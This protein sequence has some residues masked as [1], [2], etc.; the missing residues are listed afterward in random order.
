MKADKENLF[1]LAFVTVWSIFVMGYLN[2]ITI[3]SLEIGV[4]VTPQTGNVLWMGFN[5][6]F[7][8]WIAF[9]N[10]LGLFFGFVIGN[11]IP[12][13]TFNLFSNPKLQFFYAWSTFAIPVILYPFVFQYNVAPFVSLLILGIASGSSLGFFR[14][15]YSLDQINSAMATG[16]VRFIGVHFAQGFIK[17]N[18]KDIPLFYIFVLCIVAFV[19]GAFLYGMAFRFDAPGAT[20]EQFMEYSRFINYIDYYQMMGNDMQ[21]AGLNFGSFYGGLNF[22]SIGLVVL[23]IVPYFFFPKAVTTKEV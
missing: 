22:R 1:R 21:L 14:R 15:V 18:K 19:A 7:G 5:L 6:A 11:M 12:I 8:N 17:G 16:S 9:L 4:P 23:C 3:N 20:R 13:L 2:G 10:N